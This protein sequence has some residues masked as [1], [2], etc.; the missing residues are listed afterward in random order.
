MSAP[1]S[2]WRWIAAQSSS[3]S[4]RPALGHPIREREVTDVVQQTRG[5]GQLALGR[6]LI[7]TAAAMSCANRAT[8]AACRAARWSRM[9]SERMRPASTPQDSETYCSDRARARSTSWS[10]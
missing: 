6:R 2:G 4:V 1:N 7:P 9:S 3:V 5:V 10:M 8:A